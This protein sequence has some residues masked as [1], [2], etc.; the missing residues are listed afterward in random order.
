MSQIA[1]MIAASGASLDAF[2]RLRVSQPLTLFDSKQLSDNQSHVWDDQLVS[3]SGGAS[4]YNTNQAS[5]TLS[6][7]ANTAAQRVR[8]TYRRFNYQPGKSQMFMCT[9]I[10]GT[11]A[12]GITRRI[13][14]FDANNGIFFE[15]GPSNVAVVIRTKT[16]GSASDTRF[17]QSSW[18]LDKLDET[19]PSQVTADWSRVQ[20]IGA[21]FEWLG[22]GSVW[23][24]VVI[25]G[26]MIPVHRADHSNISTVVYM[27][28]P[29]LP[30]RYEINNSGTGGAAGLTHM[31]ST[32][33]TEG[34]RSQTGFPR[35]IT[36]GSTSFT[37]NN[38]S[39]LYPLIALRLKSTHLGCL[40]DIE[41]I[42]I[43][44][45]TS[46]SFE[47][48]LMLNPTVTGTALSFSSATTALEA[49]VATTNAT[50]VSG[51]TFTT[52]EMRQQSNEGSS[53]AF[54]TSD[55]RIGSNIAGTADIIVLAVRRFSVNAETFY[56]SMN[57]K[58]TC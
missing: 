31:C 32:V 16:S 23:F 38:D 52:G 49:D 51:G 22:T 3:G 56:A 12:T 18:N 21:F 9:G 41:N 8:Q 43:V 48:V 11:P 25:N 4:T 26:Q 47:W 44:C 27:S 28:T 14:M 46:A 1:S 50:T 54:P 19:G 13:G 20:I 17:V 15:S 7:A 42:S 30:V 55:F 6:V 40:I 36:R 2:G 35:Y 45:T 10:L 37:T 33:I 34:G 29:N 24:F 5:T 58:E 53:I 39:N 57:I